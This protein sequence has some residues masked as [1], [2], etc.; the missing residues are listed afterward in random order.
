MYF[1]LPGYTL[2]MISFMPA[3]QGLND[4]LYLGDYGLNRSHLWYLFYP[5][6]LQVE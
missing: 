1:S 3:G 5:P 2:M 6:A 4:T